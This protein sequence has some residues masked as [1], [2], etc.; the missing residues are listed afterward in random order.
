[1]TRSM[2]AEVMAILETAYRDLPLTEEQAAVW[3]ALLSP[4]ED[5]AVK[6]AAI[7]VCR[8]SPYR[9]KPADLW[10]LARE[11]RRPEVPA[12]LMLPE[13]T[14][15]ERQR[16]AVAAKKARAQIRR[17][18]RRAKGPLAATLQAVPVLNERE[19][20]RRQEERDADGRED[21]TRKEDHL[22]DP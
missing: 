12:I 18:L 2:F 11:W 8:T 21:R 5:E 19:W 6:W 9:P 13:P 10:R 20:K 1:M 7:E 15:E 4:L 17:H 14:E 16:T 3:F 22:G